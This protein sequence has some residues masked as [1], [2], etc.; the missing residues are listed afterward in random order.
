MVLL[1]RRAGFVM[2][3]LLLHGCSGVF[4]YP[5]RQLVL[6]PTAAKLSY[7]EVSIETPD[8][9]RLHGWYLPAADA[10][11]TV[12][13]LHG[14][15]GNIS[16]HLGSVYWLPREGYNVLLLDFRGYGESQGT[17][18]VGGSV[19]DAESALDWLADRPEVRSQGVAVLGQSLGG[20]IAI[21]TVAHSRHRDLIRT[22]IADSA[23]ASYRGIAREK[24]AG[25]WLTWAV[26]WPLSLTIGDH[27]S[28]V[29]AIPEVSPIP[30]LVIH[31]VGDPVIPVHH[32][33][34][35]YAAAREPKAYWRLPE[36]GHITA[37]VHDDN[38]KRLV[39][40]LDQAFGR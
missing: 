23:F 15:A 33:D 31:N 14:N 7:D 13:F 35:L 6:T 32:G 16:T 28:P 5:Q 4:F 37:L 20:A 34:R 22:L 26:Q 17:A 24:L 40:Y 29:E 10:K 3:L 18:S 19:L 12:L 27:Y 25:W 39:T 38:R 11:G 36:D 30:L 8:H 2:L 21:Y 1:M 9:V